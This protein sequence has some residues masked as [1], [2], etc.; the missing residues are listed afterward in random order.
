MIE[1]C[2]N[3][4]GPAHLGTLRTY[5]VA[6]HEARKLDEPL[7]LLFEVFA[8]NPHADDVWATQFLRELGDLDLRPDFV[9]YFREPAV[10]PGVPS[11]SHVI[12]GNAYFPSGAEGDVPNPDPQ[13]WTGPEVPLKPLVYPPDIRGTG[14]AQV[15]D[16]G[17][18]VLHA[19]CSL[20][21]WRVF[22]GV[23][24]VVRSAISAFIAIC[25]DRPIE[26]HFGVRAPRVIDTG[27]VVH[28]A[29]ALSKHMLEPGSPGTVQWAIEEYGAEHVR[30]SVLHSA[31]QDNRQI[32]PFPEVLDDSSPQES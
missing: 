27:V 11:W 1:F 6:W 8:H 2:P 5:A 20:N 22:T 32:I 19:P 24:G 10:L 28:D 25:Y 12:D 3:A 7:L 21:A 30:A 29:G 13:T 4:T 23:T 15:Q 17:R 16:D 18:W 31:A 26:Q 14:F 9:D